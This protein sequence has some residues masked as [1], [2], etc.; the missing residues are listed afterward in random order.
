MEVVVNGVG[1]LFLKMKE[2]W[3]IDVG[4]MNEQ[5]RD[6]FH[7]YSRRLCKNMLGYEVPL[8]VVTQINIAM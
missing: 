4:F 5:A 3:L 8:T 1:G 2:T 7:G 6:Y